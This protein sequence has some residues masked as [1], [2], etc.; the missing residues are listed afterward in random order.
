MKSLTVRGVD[1]RVYGTLQAL[2]KANRRSL[3]EQVKVILEREVALA[4]TGSVARCRAARERLA[5]R[6][7]GDITAEIREDRG[8]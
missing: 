3:Q 5:S 2:A 8:R 1:D 7:W 4:Q 6:D